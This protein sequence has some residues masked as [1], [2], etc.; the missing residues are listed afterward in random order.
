[1]SCYLFVHS[2]NDG[3]ANLHPQHKAALEVLLQ[4]QRLQDGHQEQQHCIHVPLPDIPRFVLS[5]RDHQS[6]R[7]ITKLVKGQL[8]SLEIDL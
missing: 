3:R 6:R 8:N 4:E 7:S 2:S 5:E 1:M